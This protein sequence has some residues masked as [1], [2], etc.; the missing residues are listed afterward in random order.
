[1]QSCCF[2][3]R[4]HLLPFFQGRSHCFGMYGLLYVFFPKRRIKRIKTKISL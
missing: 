2:A 1:M 4:T 3:H